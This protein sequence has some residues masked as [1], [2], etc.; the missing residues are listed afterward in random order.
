MPHRRRSSAGRLV[1]PR[2]ETLAYVVASTG[3]LQLRSYKARRHHLSM[4][5]P[6]QTPGRRYERWADVPERE[7]ESPRPIY[8]DDDFR[9]FEQFGSYAGYRVGITSSEWIFFVGGD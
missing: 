9:K 6:S 8:G 2:W 1:C 3:A 7:R 5:P 4:T